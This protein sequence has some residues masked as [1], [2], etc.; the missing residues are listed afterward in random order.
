MLEAHAIETKKTMDTA[1][2]MHAI[3]YDRYGP[4]EVLE[5]R[6]VQRPEAR[7]GQVLIQVQAA[8]VNPAEWHMMTGTPRLVRLMGTGLLR[9]KNGRL[10]LDVAGV[11][12]AVG[13]GVTTH[14]VGDEVYGAGRGAY[15]E[16]IVADA[17]QVNR[18][19]D[20][21]TIEQG[22][23]VAIAA[24]TALQGLRD[25]IDIQPGQHVVINGASGGVGTFAVQIAK[26]M[27]AEVTGICSGRN[28]ELV[29]SL[30][31]DHVVDYTTD[32]FTEGDTT[33]DAIFDNVGSHSISDYRRVMKP[34][35][36]LLPVG[37]NKDAPLGPIPSMV[38]MLVHSM[39]IS[40]SIKFFVADENAADLAVLH[41]YFSAG[42]LSTVIDRT[43]PLED[44]ADALRY[45]ET[46]RA[47][48]KVV[49]TTS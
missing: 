13:D 17:G 12:T 1:N 36:V 35:A 26:L 22:G 18:L 5:Y 16:Y 19:P 32:N 6:E 44:A 39:L 21:M 38:K 30:G 9:P 47:R 45:L 31:A 46:Q 8:G 37:G 42:E 43:Y 14:N 10:G 4:P 29:R 23:G 7:D 49:L 3:T 48:G 25:K 34:K 27:G 41:N 40:Q 2:T 33:Y 20:G 11:V 24:V 15:A 28:V